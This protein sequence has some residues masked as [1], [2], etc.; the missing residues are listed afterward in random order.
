MIMQK[1]EPDK[2]AVQEGSPYHRDTPMGASMKSP[3]PRH[4]SPTKEKI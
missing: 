1:R 3:R 2:K 4:K